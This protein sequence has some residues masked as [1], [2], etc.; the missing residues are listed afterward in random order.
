MTPL[1]NMLSILY[2]TQIY[3]RN[4]ES[5]M[6]PCHSTN[7]HAINHGQS[8]D[9]RR[10]HNS[11][12]F[13]TTALAL[14]LQLSDCTSPSFPPTHACCV[15]STVCSISSHLTA[16]GGGGFMQPAIPTVILQTRG[17]ERDLSNEKQ[18]LQQTLN[19]GKRG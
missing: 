16:D 18:S 4:N 5:S 1:Y 7:K 12:A 17:R 11:T 15:R 19:R 10:Y 13:P 14:T 6:L 2:S 8:K 9:H 3:T